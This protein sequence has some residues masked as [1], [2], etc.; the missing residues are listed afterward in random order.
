MLQRLLFVAVY[1]RLASASAGE[2]LS[3]VVHGFPMDFSV[4]GYLSVI[5][6]LLLTAGLWSGAR[7][8]SIAWK[9]WFGIVALLLSM[10]FCM[11]L[12]LYGYWGFR[13]DMT[14]FFYFTTSPSSALASVEWWQMIAGAV[15]F[16][17]M[18]A[19]IYFALVAVVLRVKVRPLRKV[20]PTA[21]MILLTAALFIPIRGGFTVSTMN[22]SR[23]YFSKNQRLN[24]I[25]INPAFSLLYSLSHQTDFASQYRFMSDSEAMAE[26]G[27]MM[28]HAPAD[29]TE[30]ILGTS[31]PDIYIIILE[32]FSAHLMPSLGGE[33]IAS[34]LD[35]IARGGLLFTNFYANSF[36]TD[37]A[38]PSILSGFPAQPS[39]SIM[40]F[41]EKTE[42][43]PSL[44]GELIKAGYVPS[45]YYGGDAN[46]TNMQAYLISSGFENIVSDKDFALKDKTGKWGAP[47]GKV[48]DRVLADVRACDSAGAPPCLRV[49]QTSSSHEPFE[50]PYSDPRFSDDRR[51]NAFAYTDRCLSEFIEKLKT[52]ERWPQT[53][54]VI[55]P[56]HYGVYPDN[57][58]DARLRHH[59]PLVMTGGALKKQGTDDTFGSQIDIAATLLAQ[60]GLDASAFPFSKNLLNPRSPHFAVFT[61]P[62][63]IGMA[64]ADGEYLVLNC[65]SEDVI[66]ASASGDT[67]FGRRTRAFLQILYDNIAKL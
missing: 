17:A 53:L 58:S 5:P 36:R 24:H 42:K 2:I 15:G 11:D 50:V 39:T 43:L 12:A 13:L 8:I 60:L 9:V 48:F 40:K 66:D 44:S 47:D 59:V 63:L 6:G 56:D 51:K 54:V 30:I 35:S 21:V 26:F 19:G 67:L 57:I 52:S 37:R 10:V 32:S 3:A 27:E 41:V 65:D 28:D 31:R 34:G 45:Y 7:W 55:V 22:L 64:T 1:S 23:A 61:E 38:L 46:F 29:S 18:A 25:A 4:A 62:S 20:A 33:D 14:P 49:V 16:I